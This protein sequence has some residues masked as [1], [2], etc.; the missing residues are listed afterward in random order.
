[1][2]EKVSGGFEKLF[3]STN[4][5]VNEKR[6]D[7]A[8]AQEEREFRIMLGDTP[9]STVTG[10]VMIDGSVYVD[11]QKAGAPDSDRLYLEDSKGFRFKRVMLPVQDTGGYMVFV[12]I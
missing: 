3:E 4:E 10:H 2:N 8:N 7:V 9:Q 12:Q 1:M 5:P 6:F 11:Q